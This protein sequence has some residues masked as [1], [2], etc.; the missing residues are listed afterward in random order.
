MISLWGVFGFAARVKD[1]DLFK[2]IIKAAFCI[3]SRDLS[4]STAS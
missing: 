3:K 1:F 2:K 4:E